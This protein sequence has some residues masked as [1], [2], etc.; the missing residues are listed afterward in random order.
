[1]ISTDTH[2]VLRRSYAASPERIWALWTTP[3]GIG[4][5]WAPD[6]FST[7]VEV[8]DLRPG[9]ALV[10]TM[11]ATGRDQV[12]FMQDAGIPLSTTSRKEFTAVEQ[13]TRLAYTSVIDFVPEHEPYEHLTV[14]T[15]ERTAGGCTDVTMELEPLHD[16]VWTERIQAG[17]ANE[18]D[19]LARLISGSSL[20]SERRSY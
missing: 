2:L 11:T 5:W 12:A 17:R 20:R 14:V 15:L 1:M 8:L 16:D 9:G 6:G 10:C 19:N 3:E 13:P 7:S 4:S 18:L